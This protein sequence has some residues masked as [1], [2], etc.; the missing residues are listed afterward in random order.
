MYL[1]QIL[2]ASL[3]MFAIFLFDLSF[4]TDGSSSQA[5]MVQM[6]ISQGDM[7]YPNM[8]APPIGSKKG[9]SPR[10]YL[11][12]Q[13][14]FPVD[15][16]DQWPPIYSEPKKIAIIIPFQNRKEHLRKWIAHFN[17]YVEGEI[18]QGRNNKYSVFVAEQEV[19]PAD[20]YFRKGW[21]TNCVLSVLVQDDAF[22][23]IIEIDV[24]IIPVLTDTNLAWCEWPTQPIR[25]NKKAIMWGGAISMSPQHWR[26]T[27]GFS[28]K[29]KGWGKEDKDLIDRAALA[30]L[31]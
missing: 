4:A 27:N 8:T 7:Q 17:E 1:Q 16:T 24:D 3:F 6:E 28:N 22:D 9:K 23:C 21:V 12:G 20:N 31:W 29:F 26:E 14:C 30:G 13:P 19:A 10:Q 18:E 2:V 5:E 11:P 25:W 15:Q